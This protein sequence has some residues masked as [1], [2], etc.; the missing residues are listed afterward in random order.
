MRIELPLN[1]S[2]PTVN[3]YFIPEPVPTLIDCGLHTAQTISVLE[4]ALQAKGFRLAD[5]LKV[6]ITHPH[7]DHIGL[8]GFFAE[9]GAEIWISDMAA[10]WMDNREPARR[11]TLELLLNLMREHGFDQAFIHMTERFYHGLAP[12]FTEIP[13]ANRRLFRV[14]DMIEIGHSPYEV[15][16]AP[17]H[18]NLQVCFYQPTTR[19]LFSADMLLPKT[20]VPVIEPMH[21]TSGTRYPGLP[22]LLKSYRVYR[23]LDV[24]VVYPGHGEPFENHRGLIDAQVSRI[25][26][27]KLECLTLIRS[28]NHTL[29]GLLEDMYRTIPPNARAGGLAMLV[30]Y[31]DLLLDEDLIQP[32]Y[33]NGIRRFESN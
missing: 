7:V 1:I 32:V 24:S 10:D 5:I 9:K 3:V 20:P 2:Y 19:R 16:A 28:G 30:G 31:I 22:A 15:L 18:T 29:P 14:G 26:R 8:A 12:M 21:R 33:K 17:G 27:R 11:D 25:Q 23:D 13:D 6:V 4:V